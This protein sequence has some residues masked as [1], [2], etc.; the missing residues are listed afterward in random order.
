MTITL[1]SQF[2]TTGDASLIE[3]TIIDGGGDTVI[4]VDDSVGPGA[5][6]I[7]LTI[8]NGEDGIS[9]AGNVDILNNRFIGKYSTGR[10]RGDILPCAMGCNSVLIFKALHQHSMTPCPAEYHRIIP[11]LL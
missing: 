9:Q 8:Q 7:G 2:H 5:R 1:A 6:V 11:R 3:Q 4:T 10:S